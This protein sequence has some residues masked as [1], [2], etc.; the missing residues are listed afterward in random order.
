MR[1]SCPQTDIYHATRYSEK[2]LIA[3]KLCQQACLAQLEAAIRPVRSR[4]SGVLANS[5]TGH[6]GASL[7]LHSLAIELG[8]I[9]F[10]RMIAQMMHRLD[11]HMRPLGW[12]L[13]LVYL[14]VASWQQF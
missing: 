12:A 14:R 8:M 9:C 3:A 10:S 13:Y 6:L 7:S 5:R 2:E 11:T 4:L 1:G